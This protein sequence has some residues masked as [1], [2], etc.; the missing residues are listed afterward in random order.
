M[1]LRK[2]NMFA[3]IYNYKMLAESAAVRNRMDSSFSRN[4][5]KNTPLW[6]AARLGLTRLP[7]RVLGHQAGPLQIYK[8]LTMG[9]G[10][11][12]VRPLGAGVAV[13][14]V[15]GQLMLHDQEFTGVTATE[16]NAMH[17][18]TWAGEKYD[19][20]QFHKEESN[21]CRYLNS[22]S[23][24]GKHATL[25]GKWALNGQLCILFTT[26]AVKKG[27]VASVSYKV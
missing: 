17:A 1:H 4:K 7:R 9:L 26:R 23:G 6:K 8:T 12:F 20:C 13:I 16:A 22:S 25:V 24:T 18:Y 14:A 27:D 3:A 11:R 10:V 21:I 19:I 15:R 2:Q 5:N